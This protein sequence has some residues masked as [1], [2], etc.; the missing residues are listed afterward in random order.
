MITLIV[1][2]RLFNIFSVFGEICTLVMDINACRH[3]FKISYRIKNTHYRAS[4]DIRQTLDIHNISCRL[5][6]LLYFKVF[7]KH[8]YT[9]GRVV[10][11]VV[12]EALGLFFKIR[13]AHGKV[14]LA[15]KYCYRFFTAGII[16]AAAAVELLRRIALV[17]LAEYLLNSLT[18]G[19]SL[20]HTDKRH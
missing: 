18:A 20:G 15:L 8:H 4:H 6:Y 14:C 7:A 19:H 5:V 9:V 3:N 16:T 17:H 13:Q 2:Y 12:G 1:D 10:Y 11:Y